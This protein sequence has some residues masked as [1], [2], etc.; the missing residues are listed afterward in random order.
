MG[1]DVGS[2]HGD[3]RLETAGFKKSVAVINKGQTDMTKKAG[4]ASSAFKGL[5][6]QMAVGL[7]IGA[8]VAL[9]MRTFT[10]QLSDTIK[11]GR[12][13]EKEWANVTTMLSISEKETDKLK[14]A[15]M[16]LS[17]T[18]GGTTELAKGMYQVLSASIEPAKAIEFLG[19]AAKAAQAGVTDVYTSVD[20]LTTVINAYGMAAEDA[21]KVSDIMFATV[22]RGKLTYGELAGALGTVVPVAAT[23]GIEFEEVAAAL[24]SLTRQGI[25]VQTATMQLRQ[26]F[27]AVLKPGKD[28]KDLAKKLG[29]EFSVAALKAKGLAKFLEDVKIKT[30]GSSTAISILFKNVRAMTPV[31]ALTGRAAKGLAKDILLM[32]VASGLSEEAFRKQMKTTD[33]WIRT[34]GFATD[35]FK[36]AFWD[37]F[38]TPLKEGIKSSKDLEKATKELMITFREMGKLIGSIVV[39]AY[40][41]LMQHVN[42]A[43]NLNKK[44]KIVIEGISLAIKNKQIPTL[45]NVTKAWVENYIE[46]KKAKEW[47]D[48]NKESIASFI[49]KLTGLKIKL[50]ETKEGLEDVGKGSKEL[51]ETVK[52]VSEE[53]IKLVKE[54]TDEIKKATLDEFEYRKLKA[55]QIYEE[56]KALLE[57][58]GADREAFMLLEKARIT[59]LAEIE[60]DLT[61][62]QKKEIDKRVKIYSEFWKKVKEKH[63]EFKGYLASYADIVNQ[64]VMNEFDY[65]NLKIDEWHEYELQVLQASLGNSKEYYEAKTLLD[66]A[67]GIKKKQFV[68]DT[69][70]KIA[71]EIDKTAKAAQAAWEKQYRYW[72]DLCKNMGNTFGNFTKSILT[73]GSDLKDALAGLW[74]DILDSFRSMIAN[75]V[76]EWTTKFLLKILE[77]T[78]ETSSDIVDELGKI[79]TGAS[80]AASSAGSAFSSAFA[81]A[82]LFLLPLAMIPFVNWLDKIFPKHVVTAAERAAMTYAAAFRKQMQKESKKAGTFEW[83]WKKGYVVAE[84]EEPEEGWQTGFTGIVRSPM[85]PLIG[86]VPEFVFIKPLSEMRTPVIDTGPRPLAP[87]MFGEGLTREVAEIRHTSGGGEEVGG[88][89]EVHIH[90]PLIQTTGISRSDLERVG[91]ELR[92]IVEYQL[93]RG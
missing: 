75:M 34:M 81:G 1:F 15:L 62:K 49:E 43:F 51:G 39:P 33:F 5:W 83:E 85:R 32:K 69:E 44:M 29:L 55:Q 22:K 71:K 45:K 92:R 48:K 61:E 37:G 89:R 50:G 90:G 47:A 24:A 65:K 8:G 73:K 82:A 46:Q 27:M 3:I 84:P 4:G 23:V 87:S 38:T 7:G 21:T 2:V 26:V 68:E 40:K 41:G 59:T 60:E 54:M 56:R 6:K 78:K 64:Y 57:K 70:K 36:I 11:K 20:A 88:K 19:V 14:R 42:K 25:N 79:K 28:A 67:Y 35:K 9:V 93:E 30:G 13:F 72:I 31:M 91:E 77:S 17:P 53:I 76:A 52:K 86:E 74:N 80:S 16:N 18:L 10:R 58:E 66:E 63:E 12:E